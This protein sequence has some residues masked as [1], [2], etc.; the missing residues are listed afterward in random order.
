MSQKTS[1]EAEIRLRVEVDVGFAATDALYPN[2]LG[3][4]EI[5]RLILCRDEHPRRERLFISIALPIEIGNEDYR[6][7]IGY[8]GF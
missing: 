5:I 1:P 3:A 7:V 8:H 2:I 4:G 6:V